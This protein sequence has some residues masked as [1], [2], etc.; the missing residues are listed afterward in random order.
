MLL[1]VLLLGGCAE[2][3]S[4][5]VTTTDTSST[6]ISQ[7]ES[8]SENESSP[9]ST[10]IKSTQSSTESSS[11]NP[12]AQSRLEGVTITPV[13]YTDEDKELQKILL[14]LQKPTEE[15]LFWLVNMTHNPVLKFRFPQFGNESVSRYALIPENH[16]LYDDNLFDKPTTR[17]GLEKIMLEYFSEEFT[18]VRTDDIAVCTMTEN[19]DGTYSVIFTD[20]IDQF[21]NSFLHSNLLEIDG[22][23]YQ[24]EGL[25]PVSINM[26]CETAKIISK[27]DDTI[28]FSYLDDVG[29]DYDQYLFNGNYKNEP[30]YSEN[31]LKGSLKYE[32]GGWKL[33]SFND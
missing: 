11:I 10:I 33:N 32:R 27:T 13:E 30:F 14:D 31:A 23:L 15:I 24:R 6:S 29:D 16:R 2:I 17:D 3:S 20:G 22:R 12:F 19:P 21:A 18:K 26:D 5:S 7:S 8:S 4:N 1:A 28:E 25:K 9:Q